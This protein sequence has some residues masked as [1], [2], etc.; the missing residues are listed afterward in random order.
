MNVAL[1]LLIVML[2]T[3]TLRMPGD[4]VSDPDLWWHLADARILCQTHHFIHVEPYSFTVAGQPWVNP[5]WLS[6]LPYWFA[7]QSFHLSG[8]FFLTLL[9][10]FANLVFIYWRCCRTGHHAGAA[11][12]AAAAGFPLMTVNGGPRTIILAY[13]LMSAEMAI[14]D[15]AA[16]GKPRALWLLPLVF[17]IWINF[18]GSWLIGFCLFVL[19][20]LCEVFAVNAGIFQ[21]QALTSAD[22]NRLV[23]VLAVSFAALFVNPYGWLLLWN[24]V[25]MMMNQK[26]SHATVQEWHPLSLSSLPGMGA[27][28]VIALTVLA[29]S[30]SSRKWKIYQFAFL[31]FAW[32]AAFDHSRFTFLAA[33]ITIPMLAGDMARAFFTEPDTK[34]IPAMNALMVAGSL[35]I[36]AYL[37]PSQ[38]ILNRAL[39]IEFPLKTIASIQP[40]WR[41]FNADAQ[42]GMIN[43]DCKPSF[44][45]SRFDTF[46]HHGVLADYMDIMELRNSLDLLDKYR[47]DHVL[48][49]RDMAL[50]YLLERMPGW[51]VA[52]R[53]GTGT[54]TFE[55]FARTS[56][57]TASSIPGS[58]RP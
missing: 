51:T 22:R 21:Q 31:A 17:C 38:A 25:D 26:L 23:Q 35:G 30:L 7:Y 46:D 42:G 11:F 53:E 44:I 3:R 43:F 58:N 6:E 55:L 4:L 36:V 9:A 34:T 37:I 13:L 19:Y 5:E 14:L 52:Q 28:V 32:F 15:A 57:P 47:I 1:L 24:P 54:A 50:S 39:S 16:R 49:P 45:D 12:W 29:N 20:I 41:T 40:G 10:L 18:H 33:V 8:L 48:L 56:G 27:I 2:M